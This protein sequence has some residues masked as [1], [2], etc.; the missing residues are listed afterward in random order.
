M[1]IAQGIW[2]GGERQFHFKMRERER[3][4]E[5]RRET[6]SQHNPESL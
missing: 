2:K 3:E 4:R 5:K 1:E 6:N